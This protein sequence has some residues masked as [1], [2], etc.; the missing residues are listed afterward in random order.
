MIKQKYLV[1]L[2]F[3]KN[4]IDIKNIDFK[5]APITFIIGGILLIV[6]VVYLVIK[7]KKINNKKGSS[8][9]ETDHSNFT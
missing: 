5:E 3:Q 8:T 7:G 9:Y 2:F 1:N 6:L 4:E